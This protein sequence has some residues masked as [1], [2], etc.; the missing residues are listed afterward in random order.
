MEALFISLA[1]WYIGIGLF[2][3]ILFEILASIY[4]RYNTDPDNESVDKITWRDRF[5]TVML[6]PVL[7]YKILAQKS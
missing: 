6:W 1:N 5:A 2:F 3:L 7:L 4:E